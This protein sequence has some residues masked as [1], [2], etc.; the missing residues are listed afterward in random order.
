MGVRRP[1]RIDVEHANRNDNEQQLG[2]KSKSPFH[3]AVLRNDF[4]G[5]K[6]IFDRGVPNF[7]FAYNLFRSSHE[8]FGDESG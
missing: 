6:S 3:N 5:S 8:Y 1:A 2:A 7:K 4:S